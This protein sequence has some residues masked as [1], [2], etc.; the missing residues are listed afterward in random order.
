MIR[1]DFPGTLYDFLYYLNCCHRRIISICALTFICFFLSPLT[2]QENIKIPQPTVR[3][4]NDR[5]II[6]YEIMG[7]QQDDRFKV[8]L[9]ITD[10][11]GNRIDAHSLYGDIG[12]EVTGGPSKQIIWDLAADSMYL[13]MD[14]NIEIFATR[15][16]KPVPVAVAA[17]VANREGVKSDTALA[18]KEEE[19]PAE[20]KNDTEAG[21]NKEEEV[22]ET[23]AETAVTEKKTETE[24]QPKAEAEGAVTNKDA[25]EKKEKSRT[26][27]SMR[28]GSNL[29]LSTACPGWGL[30]R[31]SGGKPYWLIGVTG[32][33]CIGSSVYLNRVSHSN[34]EK[35]LETSDI[36]NTGEMDDYYNTGK[37]QYTASNVLAWSA[38]TI[39]VADLGLTWFL[40][41][42]AQRSV[43]NSGS[44]SFSVGTSFD[45]YADTP[46]ISIFYTF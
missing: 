8:W 26:D 24:P 40:T 21:K 46:M 2:A 44:G 28:V 17:V 29:L 16:I 32:F 20:M 35:Y 9:E 13:N 30:T 36:N 19:Q 37:K 22:S 38:L 12:N 34:Y 4:L 3:F 27:K 41:S 15:N 6:K 5:L 43:L 7:Y 45:Y 14:L 11:T 33:A 31:L 39:W 18:N 10:S 42:K 1:Y 23:K 25:S